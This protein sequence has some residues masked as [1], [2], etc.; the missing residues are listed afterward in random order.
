MHQA[1][2]PAAVQVITVAWRLSYKG[3]WV[4]RR[5][6]QASGSR[7]ARHG[8]ARSNQRHLQRQSGGCMWR[9]RLS[10]AGGLKAWSWVSR[11]GGGDW[12]VSVFGWGSSRLWVVTRWFG[13]CDFR[14]EM[15]MSRRVV[16]NDYV[17]W[18]TAASG[19]CVGCSYGGSWSE[20]R[21][22]MVDRWLWMWGFA[23]WGYRRHSQ[24]SWCGLPGLR[25]CWLR[26]APNGGVW[27]FAWVSWRTVEVR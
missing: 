22:L 27:C 19:C 11:V 13:C 23:M 25:W 12:W 6:G 17:W 18:F 4:G 3:R 10:E 2:G 7:V 15:A 24:A 16:G 5:W 9:C 8:V 21:L 26:I 1:Y 20:V 14:C